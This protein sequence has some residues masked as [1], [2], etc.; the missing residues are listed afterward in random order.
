MSTQTK[1]PLK[2]F[3]WVDLCTHELK[4]SQEFYRGLF[5]WEPKMTDRDYG[6]FELKGEAVGGHYPMPAEMAEHQVP[7]H[8]TSYVLVDDVDACAARV[9]ELG[10]KVIMPGFPVMEI[11]RMAVVADPTGGRFAL[12]QSPEEGTILRGV[13][14][15]VCWNELMTTDVEKARDFYTN[16]FGWGTKVHREPPYTEFGLDQHAVGGLLRQ[17][18]S[19]KDVPPAWM[20]YFQVPDCAAAVERAK[21]LG[22][23]ALNEIFDIPNVGQL[24]VLR[25]PYGAT[26]AVIKMELKC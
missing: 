4:G 23:T 10:G 21:V 22:G 20:V 16:L 25:D 5:G 12:W 24:C 1:T 13:D 3:C 9:A 8:W 2:T 15:T 19:C 7:S 6:M 17:P 26:F 11:H 18:E 14:H